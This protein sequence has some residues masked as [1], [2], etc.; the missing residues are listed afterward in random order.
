M[1][2]LRLECRDVMFSLDLIESLV[3]RLWGIEI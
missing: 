3:V 2:G 1:R